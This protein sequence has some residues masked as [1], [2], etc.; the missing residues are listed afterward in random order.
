MA[1]IWEQLRLTDLLSAVGAFAGRA[2]SLPP[3]SFDRP[4]VP[5]DVAAALAELPEPVRRGVLD[6]LDR[7]REP[8]TTGRPVPLLLPSLTVGAARARQVDASTCGSA[9]LAMLALAGDARLALRL[10]RAVDPA[11]AFGAL[12]R[13]VK[14]AT[15]RTVDGVPAWP[16]DLGTPPWG[17]ARVARYGKVRYT[18]R[19]VSEPGRAGV[20][21]SGNVWSAV[22][23]A[24]RAGVPVPL[25]TGGDLGH[26]LRTAVPRHVVL[27]T[28]VGRADG[29][30]V[31]RIYEPSSGAVHTVPF[32]V[33]GVG[34]A[35]DSVAVVRAA[36][37]AALGG[38]PHVTWALLP[39]GRS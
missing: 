35:S 4:D 31:A 15:N 16:S 34:G 9:V 29:Q 25:F 28:A 10:A 20:G 2:P 13:S 18:H 21:R 33:L 27:L 14:R 8:G 12:Q 1:A 36:R 11:S 26:G 24:V 19:V 30:D 5:D 6:P 3:G 22:L 39:S 37:L 23:D 32:G 7:D 17:A 38:W